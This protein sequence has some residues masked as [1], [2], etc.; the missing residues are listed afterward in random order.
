MSTL[1][2]SSYILLFTCRWSACSLFFWGP[3]PIRISKKFQNHFIAILTRKPNADSFAFQIVF[4]FVCFFFCWM[5]SIPECYLWI[6]ASK[7]CAL[8]VLILYVFIVNNKLWSSICKWSCFCVFAILDNHLKS[9]S[10]TVHR[11]TSTKL[12]VVSVG[13]KTNKTKSN[14]ESKTRL[15]CENADFIVQNICISSTKTFRTNVVLV[16]LN[17]LLPAVPEEINHIP[18][19]VIIRYHNRFFFI[20]FLLCSQKHAP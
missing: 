5:S 10:M 19:I 7:D 18:Q 12:G 11:F 8:Y 17:D 9:Q 6:F 13:G 2:A 15:I 1:S 16:A 14:S 3:R 20:F 4:F